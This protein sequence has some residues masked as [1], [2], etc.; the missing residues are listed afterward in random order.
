[1]PL[2]KAD[3]WID[4]FEGLKK[5]RKSWPMGGWSWDTRLSCVTSSFGVQFEG[6]ARSA[7]A[8]ALPAE[9]TQASLLRA[10]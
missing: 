1:M 7:A 9:W 8:Q 10:P 3:A 2:P 4:V 6:E 5:L